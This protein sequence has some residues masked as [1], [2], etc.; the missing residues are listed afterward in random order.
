MLIRFYIV[1]E[2]KVQSLGNWERMGT[3]FEHPSSSHGFTK[4]ESAMELESGNF[5]Y[6]FSNSISSS[7]FYLE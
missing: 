7:S 5:G 6:F 2:E 4:N 1:K 3:E